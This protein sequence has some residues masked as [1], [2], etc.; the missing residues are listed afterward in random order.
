MAQ[1]FQIEKWIWTDN[2]FDSMG[3][4]DSRIHALS[5]VPEQYEIVFDIDY[6]FQWIP[7]ESNE[8][9]FKFWVAPATLVFENIYD[10]EFDIES[11]DGDLEIDGITRKDPAKPLNGQFTGKDV[12]WLWV[13]ECQEGEIRFRSDG[14]KQFIRAAPQ[15]GGAQSID[16]KRRGFSFARSRM[17]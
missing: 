4:H 15:L 3:W 16:L 6:I 14:Y 12:D 1:I 5:F 17:E 2:D 9:H 13:I 11:H 8:S 7:P 10:L